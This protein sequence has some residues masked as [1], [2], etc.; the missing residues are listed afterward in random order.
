MN[1][2]LFLLAPVSTVRQTRQVAKGLTVPWRTSYQR[3]T[4]WRDSAVH[5]AHVAGTLLAWP[6]AMRAELSAVR[7]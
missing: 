7:S 2:A 4:G 3:F 6:L 5:G 1:T